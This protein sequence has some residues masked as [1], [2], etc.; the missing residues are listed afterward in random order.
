VNEANRLAD[1][2]DMAI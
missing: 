2:K 1:T